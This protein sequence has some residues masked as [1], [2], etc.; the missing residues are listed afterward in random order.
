MQPAAAATQPI[1]LATPLSRSQVIKTANLQR[2]ETWRQSA[3]RFRMG[4]MNLT[5]AKNGVLIQSATIIGHEEHDGTTYFRLRMCATDEGYREWEVLRRYNQFKL[6]HDE[7]GVRD[8]RV[9]SIFPK[10][11]GLFSCRDG[12]LGQRVIFLQNWTDGLLKEFA[13]GGDGRNSIF[14]INRTGKLLALHKFFGIDLAGRLQPDATFAVFDAPPRQEGLVDVAQP[15]APPIAAPGAVP[16]PL[17]PPRVAGHVEGA[18]LPEA[19]EIDRGHS[20]GPISSEG[21]VVQGVLVPMA[22]PS[23]ETSEAQRRSAEMEE[24]QMRAAHEASLRMQREEADAQRRRELEDVRKAEEESLRLAAEIEAKRAAEEEE[25]L[26][27]RA[28]EEQRLCAEADARAKAEEE[29]AARRKAEEEREER[30]R[31]EAEEEER[32]RAEEELRRQA[33]EEEEEEARLKAASK[34]ERSWLQ[35]AVDLERSARD[36]E[37]AGRVDEATQVFKNC[38]ELFKFLVKREKN[39]RVKEM[40][41]ARGE[42][43]ARHGEALWE[44]RAREIL[45]RREDP[46]V[47]AVAAEATSV[48]AASDATADAAAAISARIAA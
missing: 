28:E 14:P 5:G 12:A 27:L 15:S 7:L 45:E 48:E 47:P 31:A 34:D 11:T 22:E 41:R 9:G 30:L 46:L 2:H 16:V 23:P 8:K 37:A 19:P 39:A 24:A 10:K 35:K 25:Q 33:E 6:L 4:V 43:V 3:R 26:R 13:A 32:L 40:L 44:A 17:A 1:P 36:L 38:A 42:E 29:E 20:S 21:I 18:L